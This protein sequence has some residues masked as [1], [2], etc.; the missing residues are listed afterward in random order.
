[1]IIINNN[2]SH[3]QNIQLKVK[4]MNHWLNHELLNIEKSS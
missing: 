2:N 1:M 4:V 3:H